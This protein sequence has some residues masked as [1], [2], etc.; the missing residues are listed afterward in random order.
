MSTVNRFL[1]SAI[2]FLVALC[3]PQSSVHHHTKALSHITTPDQV[4]WN[5]WAVQPLGHPTVALSLP[6]SCGTAR[7]TVLYY[8]NG[9]NGMTGVSGALFK[10]IPLLK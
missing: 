8:L 10:N 7:N 2:L 6:A 9:L 1:V 4:Q 5:Q 3:L